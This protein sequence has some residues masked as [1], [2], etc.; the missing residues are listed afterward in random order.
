MYAT[1]CSLAALLNSL[2]VDPQDCINRTDCSRHCIESRK[3]NMGLSTILSVTILSF[4]AFGSL[5]AKASE[6]Q[7]VAKQV[8][9]LSEVPVATARKHQEGIAQDAI[10]AS[11]GVAP[12]FVN[13]TKIYESSVQFETH[14]EY[15]VR[16]AS[17]AKQRA[18]CQQMRGNV[19]HDNLNKKVSQ[20]TGISSNDMTVSI[21]G[22][23]LATVQVQNNDSV[24]E[25]ETPASEPV[26]E[27]RDAHT[28]T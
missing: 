13:V 22:C 28:Y 26:T 6:D 10:A 8:L 5:P 21:T 17:V 27:P 24:K 25:P 3:M 23:D 1:V 16:A 2:H 15:T 18:L 14:F 12:S 20:V 7:L 9:I 19:Y 11:L 4:L